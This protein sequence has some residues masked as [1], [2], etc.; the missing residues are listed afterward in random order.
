MLPYLFSLTL[1][2]QVCKDI[3]FDIDSPDGAFY[4]N[5]QTSGETWCEKVSAAD[6]YCYRGDVPQGN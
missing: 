3:P 2:L 5:D 4:I 6:P 1:S